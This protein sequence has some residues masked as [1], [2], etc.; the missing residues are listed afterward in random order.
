[1]FF[2]ARNIDLM[3]KLSKTKGQ[4]RA[5]SQDSPAEIKTKT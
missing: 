4:E 5:I 1:M 3:E 2:F